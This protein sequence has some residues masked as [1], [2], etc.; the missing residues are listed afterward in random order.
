MYYTT[1]VSHKNIT[2][3]AFVR[4]TEI[5]FWKKLFSCLRV[6]T[7]ILCGTLC[8]TIHGIFSLQILHTG[9]PRQLDEKCMRKYSKE[10]CISLSNSG[11]YT[12]WRPLC[13]NGLLSM[14]KWDKGGAVCIAEVKFLHTEAWRE[15]PTLCK[16]HFQMHFVQR[17]CMYYFEI[18]LKFFP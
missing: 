17:K 15:W 8:N 9:L 4:E 6:K 5:T 10:W 14:H 7:T 13:N 2:F 16:Q 3:T 11:N 18:S 1:Q 12:R